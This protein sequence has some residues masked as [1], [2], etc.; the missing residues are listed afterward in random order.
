MI[1][2]IWTEMYWLINLVFTRSHVWSRLL[3]LQLNLKMM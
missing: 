1:T 2:H 3:P